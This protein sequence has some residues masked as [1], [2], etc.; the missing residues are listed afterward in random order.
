M[1]NNI[2][3]GTLDD[4]VTA[5]I[6]TDDPLLPWAEMI[7]QSIESE[8]I[9]R[10]PSAHRTKALIYTWLAWQRVPGQPMGQAITAA[11]LDY[12]SALASIFVQWLRRLFQS[13]G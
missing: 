2:I 1:P 4:F 3:P 12:N 10:Y 11:T 8:G 5:L 9:S 7:V 13:D 6:P